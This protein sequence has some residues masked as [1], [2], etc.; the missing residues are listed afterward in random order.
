MKKK[1][2]RRISERKR[3]IKRKRKKE[4]NRNSCQLVGD[5]SRMHYEASMWIFRPRLNSHF[6]TEK[7]C[8]ASV[9]TPPL[10]PPTL[11]LFVLY[12]H[13]CNGYLRWP[14]VYARTSTCI[15]GHICLHFIR[16]IYPCACIYSVCLVVS[17]Y[18][19]EFVRL[20]D[21]ELF[22]TISSITF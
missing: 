19:L 9:D 18:N 12:P 1:K 6:P 11:Y 4:W 2:K 15:H 16:T 3:R 10:T 13:M 22:P 5:S 8:V 21:H 20:Y 14:Q 7:W 17:E